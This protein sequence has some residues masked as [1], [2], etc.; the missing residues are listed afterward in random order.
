[1]IVQR[2]KYSDLVNTIFI[3]NERKQNKN[4]DEVGVT[5]LISP[6]KKLVFKKKIEL[7]Y[8]IEDIYYALMGTATHKYLSELLAEED[9]YETDVKVECEI[10]GVKIRGEIDCIDRTTNTIVDFKTTSV[11]R[12]KFNDWDNY[13]KQVNIYNYM[14]NDHTIENLRLVVFF[15]HYSIIERERS[16]N[17]PPAG[18][19]ELE[20]PM[21]S[22]EEVERYLQE[23]VKLYKQLVNLDMK[24][25]KELDI[26]TPAEKMIREEKYLLMKK[27]RKTPLGRF[28]TEKE[29][30]DYLLT[31]SNKDDF[32]IEHRKGTA[33]CVNYCVLSKMGLCKF[34]E[35]QKN[36]KGI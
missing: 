18:V 9:E 24:T 11:W 7:Q 10:E 13:F 30:Q 34:A 31:L 25:L 22:T 2:S 3:N 15:T 6:I 12:Y 4:I 8:A 19:M 23:R 27:G 28:D 21:M 5:D 16:S 26:C 35:L 33:N 20:V 32:Y 36:E 17:Y 1:M 29:A 14:L